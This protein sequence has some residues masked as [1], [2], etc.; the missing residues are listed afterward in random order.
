MKTSRFISVQS[1][2]GLWTPM[3]L[4][5]ATVKIKS[6][7]VASGLF[8][9]DAED[10][11]NIESIGLRMNARGK[12][13]SVVTLKGVSGEFLWKDLEV[14]GLTYFLYAT[15]LCGNF[16]CGMSLCGYD[17]TGGSEEDDYTKVVKE[18]G[19][20]LSTKDDP[21]NYVQDPEDGEVLD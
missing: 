19:D 15:A 20:N 18:D 13:Y 8:S 2:A 17:T 1:P 4:I 21:Y 12:A 3:Q 7:S 14:T 9:F 11:Y 10:L 6:T 16:C 5:G